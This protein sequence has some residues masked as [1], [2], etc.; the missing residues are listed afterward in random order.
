MSDPAQPPETMTSSTTHALDR[1]INNRR[2]YF[3]ASPDKAINYVRHV[4]GPA[5]RAAVDEVRTTLPPR[6]DVDLAKT[7]NV[8]HYTSLQA[9]TAMISDGPAAP[10]NPQADHR[11]MDYRFLRLYDSANLNDPS[12]GAYFLKRFTTACDVIRAPAYIASF[13]T[14]DRPVPH[15]TGRLTTHG[16]SDNLVF[17]RH[18]GHDGRGCSIS[19]PADCF[20]PDRSDLS[21]RAVAYGS[22]A[23][24]ED[25]ARLGLVVGRLRPVLADASPPGSPL[26][27]QVAATILES[28][29]ELP[30]LY[31]TSAYKYERECRLVALRSHFEDD[32]RR[33]L[34]GGIRYS[35]ERP[36]KGLGRLRM[37]GQHPCLKL[38]HILSTYSLITLGPAV[39]N[40]DSV[41][42]ALERLLESVGLRG[43]SI[44]RSPIPYRLST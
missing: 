24:D 13:V 26:E 29:G 10:D 15:P 23:A 4:I 9:L 27:R 5:L 33:P 19:I 12:E 20:A 32:G 6:H 44:E 25:A 28:L 3:E 17:W 8:V 14:T 1:A 21:L 31:K 11:P 35:F 42:Y 36:P 40:V 2:A 43:L 39:P 34:N 16:A 7:P 37:Y 38:S 22:Q 41:Q 30:Y 18:Y